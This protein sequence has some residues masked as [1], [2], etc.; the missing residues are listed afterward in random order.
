MNVDV[1]GPVGA[2]VS[3]SVRVSPA[4]RPVAE[5]DRPGWEPPLR[6]DSAESV[7]GVDGPSLYWT[8]YDG[9]A[10]PVATSLGTIEKSRL[11]TSKK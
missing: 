3:V 5:A 4:G 10:G 7:I 6:P 2:D 11:L 8:S 9:S 1:S